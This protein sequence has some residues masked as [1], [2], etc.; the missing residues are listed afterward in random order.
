MNANFYL[1][2]F[3]LF[4]LVNSLAEKDKIEKDKMYILIS[5]T[6]YMINLKE[7]PIIT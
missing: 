2:F 4:Y 3:T 5:E 7:N 6:A 1:L